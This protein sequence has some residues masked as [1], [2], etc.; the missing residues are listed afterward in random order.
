MHTGTIR[1][2]ESEQ[3]NEEVLVSDLQKFDCDWGGAAEGNI[4]FAFSTAVVAAATVA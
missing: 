1:G 3:G 2:L 4:V